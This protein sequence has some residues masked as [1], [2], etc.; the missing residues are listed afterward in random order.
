MKNSYQKLRDRMVKEQVASRGIEDKNVLSCMRNIPRHYF[1][2]LS[3]QKESYND[4]P[5]SIGFGQTISQPYMV[6][7]MTDLLKIR[8]NH[9]ILEIGTGSGYQTA[10]LAS[11]AN[12]VFTVE[13]IEELLFKS[14][15]VLNRLGF[16]NIFYML[17][18]GYFGWEEHAPFD[19]I[20]VTAAPEKVPE[21]LIKQLK[22]G[23]HLV[24]PVGGSFE[25]VL[26]IIVRKPDEGYDE[27]I[28]TGVRFVKLVNE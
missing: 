21:P 12:A 25:Q 9:K 27:E 19:G 18:N 26:K 3:H 1:V 6:A 7:L 16:R 23:G 2:P 22:A 4:Y 10:I 28:I 8:K 15:T 24:I 13:R 14:K 20:V 11:L 17:G 5:I